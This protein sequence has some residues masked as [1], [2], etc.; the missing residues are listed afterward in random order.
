VL[1]D[2]RQGLRLEGGG[3]PVLLVRRGVLEHVQRTDGARQRDVRRLRV[4]GQ[5]HARRQRHPHL[6][7]G[8]RPQQREVTH[9]VV[10]VEGPEQGIG[11]LR[12]VT[13]GPL[14]AL[15]PGFDPGR[16]QREPVPRIVAG[17]A[18]SAVPAR[19]GAEEVDGALHDEGL[20][21]A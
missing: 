8:A 12:V 14:Q 15:P 6:D 2:R 11:G 13:S 4:V 18:G 21:A 17:R 9:T 7:E 5:P 10:G 1:V 20:G 3:G 19:E 16:R